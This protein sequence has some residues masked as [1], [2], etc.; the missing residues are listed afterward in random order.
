MPRVLITDNLSAAGLALLSETP[1]LEV[2]NKSGL[3]PAQVREELQNADA[4]IVRSATR[5]TPELLEGQQRL[6]IIVRAGVGVDNIDLGAATREG[7]IVCNTPA[8]NTTSTAEHTI[9]MLMALVRNI[10]P[11]SHSMREGRWDRKSFTGTQLAGKT[12]GVVGLGRIGLA[13][14]RRC[15]GLEMNVLGYDPFLSPEKAAEQ[16]IELFR[17]LDA[18][19][20]K[21][22]IVTVHTPLSDETRGIIN[23]ARLGAMKKGVRIINCARGGIVDENALADAI[24]AKQVA[25]AAVDVFVDEPPKSDCRLPKLPQVLATPHLGA[26]TDEAQE[27]VAIEAAEIIAA[28]FSRNEVRHAVNMAAISAKE[29]EGLKPYLDLGYRLGLFMAQM[30]RGSAVKAATIT[31]QGEAASRPT[32]LI[33]NAFTAGLLQHALEDVNIIN[34]ELLARERGITITESASTIS[35]DFSSMISISLETSDGVRCAAGTIFGNEFLRLVRL[36]DYQMDAFL[37]GLML[38]YRHR[39]VPGLIGAIGTA[40][41]R[42]QVNISRM[43]LGRERNTPGGK[44]I[45]ILNLD[46]EPSE[47][48]LQEVAGHPEVTGVQLVKLPSAGAPLPWLG[49]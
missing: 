31:Y 42:H 12:I 32:R 7:I 11:A 49:M 27:Q 40:F 14:A 8:G 36:D 35:A 20:P 15:R 29:V 23:A 26:S 41:G 17:D 6:K 1:G 3:S 24:E 34:A 43:A 19:L 39:D 18:M 47:A 48:A 13:V 45:A 10:G 9:A 28:F 22:D 4:I 5:L 37:D 25:G 21:C 33:T 38:V 30:T 16:G 2:V 46:N 44:S